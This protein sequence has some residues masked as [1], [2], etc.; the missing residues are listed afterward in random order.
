[1]SNQK[2]FPLQQGHRGMG[3]LDHHINQATWLNIYQ[4][5][6]CVLCLPN[7]GMFF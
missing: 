2:N 1:M 7:D 4:L 6:F 5:L 3:I